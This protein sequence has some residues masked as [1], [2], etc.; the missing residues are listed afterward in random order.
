LKYVFLQSNRIDVDQKMLRRMQKLSKI[1]I[2]LRG[3]T[4]LET[5]APFEVRLTI[6]LF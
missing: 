5:P 4:I 6:E 3:N 2:D 1:K